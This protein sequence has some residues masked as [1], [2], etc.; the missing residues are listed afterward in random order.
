MPCCPRSSEALTRR[1]RSCPL[2]AVRHSA[3]LEARRRHGGPD[4]RSERGSVGARDRI[5]TSYRK[6]MFNDFVIVGPPE[7][8]AGIAHASN[9]VGRDATHRDGTGAAFASRGDRSGTHSREQE[10]WAL[11]KR[12]PFRDLWS[13]R[14]RACRQHC[15]SPAKSAPTH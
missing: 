10:L 15:E 9:A 5:I 13:R 14:V 6:I 4:A 11:A 7:D 12:R 8:L 2:A 3:L 1:L